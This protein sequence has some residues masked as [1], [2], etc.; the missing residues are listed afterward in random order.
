MCEMKKIFHYC[1]K[2]GCEMSYEEK[3]M[4]YVYFIGQVK[5]AYR[6]TTKRPVKEKVYNLCE[7]CKKE[8]VNVL[9]DFIG[10]AD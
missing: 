7:T 6:Q 3:S 8:T 1:D 5:G 2:C 9:D 4:I 10:G